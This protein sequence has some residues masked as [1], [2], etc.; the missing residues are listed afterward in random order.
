MGA[1]FKLVALTFWGRWLRGSGT[2]P[3][4]QDEGGGGAR[5]GNRE[6]R[7]PGVSC[8]LENR[9]GPGKGQREAAVQPGLTRSTSSRTARYPD[10][11]EA[12][13]LMAQCRARAVAAARS[14][15]RPPPRGLPARACASSSPR[16]RPGAGSERSQLPLQS[17]P[18]PSAR[19]ARHHLR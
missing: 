15:S 8:L 17:P 18:F 5:L 13:A 1:K 3:E 6:L 10:G 2:P 9:W 16:R 4:A 19:L 7:G 12:R 14:T 11:G